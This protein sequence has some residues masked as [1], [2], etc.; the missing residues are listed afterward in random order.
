METKASIPNNEV[1]FINNAQLM[2]LAVKRTHL[3]M[4]RT[5]IAILALP[6]TLVSFFISTSRFYLIFII[7][8]GLLGLGGYTD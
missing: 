1:A 8:S 7:C 6:M 5:D 4:V 3:A 2:V